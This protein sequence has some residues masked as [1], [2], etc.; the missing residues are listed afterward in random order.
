MQFKCERSCAA[1]QIQDDTQSLNCT[2]CGAD[3]VVQRSRGTIT[4]R[5]KEPKRDS[6]C[7]SKFTAELGEQLEAELLQ[8]KT[9][10]TASRRRTAVVAVVGG[11]CAVIFGA[12]AILRLLDKDANI[13]FTMALCAGGCS[14]FVLFVQRDG[15][16]IAATTAAKVADVSRRITENKRMDFAAKQGIHRVVID[17][18]LRE[19]IHYPSW[20][21]RS[22]SYVPTCVTEAVKVDTDSVQLTTNGSNY[23][24]TAIREPWSAGRSQI[25]LRLVVDDALVLSARAVVIEDQ[26]KTHTV[27]HYLDTLLVGPWIEELFGLWTDAD[28]GH[29]AQVERKITSADATE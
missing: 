7:L 5:V 16:T 15:A 8:L 22:P 24:F 6:K 25:A 29:H 4:V 10:L 20:I 27:G 9:E 13:G 23:L 17:L 18:F 11:F 26:L 1:V 19:I 14:W 12:F 3:L 21:H 28:R 2:T